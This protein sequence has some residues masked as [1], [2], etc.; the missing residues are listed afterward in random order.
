MKSIDIKLLVQMIMTKFYEYIMA[1]ELVVHTNTPHI[2]VCNNEDS[3][4]FN[5]NPNRMHSIS[6]EAILLEGIGSKFII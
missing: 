2:L 4:Y 3:L 5:N 6:S 1:T